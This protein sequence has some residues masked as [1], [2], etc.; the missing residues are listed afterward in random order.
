[1][2]ASAS[3]AAILRCRRSCCG[4]RGAAGEAEDGEADTT[5]ALRRCDVMGRDGAYAESSGVS[6]EERGDQSTEG[7]CDGENA[8]APPCPPIPPAPE[9]A[10]GGAVTCTAILDE[11]A[12][13]V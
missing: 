9:E 5:G 11:D 13:R 7:V 6:A 1:M 4:V 3:A 2:A 8:D 12:A 10:V